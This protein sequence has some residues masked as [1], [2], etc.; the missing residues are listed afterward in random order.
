[1]VVVQISNDPTVYITIPFP[2]VHL[3]LEEVNPLNGY[4]WQHAEK[5]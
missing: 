3:P 2:L 4:K 1:M 5:V